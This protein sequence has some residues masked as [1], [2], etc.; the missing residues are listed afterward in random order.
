MAIHGSSLT[1]TTPWCPALSHRPLSRAWCTGWEGPKARQSG[2]A[3]GRH[4][5]AEALADPWPWG[6]NVPQGGA[7][8]P[9]S[10]QSPG[11]AEA[12]PGARTE[13]GHWRGLLPSAQCSLCRGCTADTANNHSGWPGPA[14]GFMMKTFGW[15]IGKP[16]CFI[17]VLRAG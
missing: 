17:G 5:S 14:A 6:L 12:W 11:T 16:V 13:A 4:L 7:H 2:W 8:P 1:P 15:K 3:P 9:R 10:Q